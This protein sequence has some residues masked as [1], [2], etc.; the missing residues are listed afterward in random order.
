MY[1]DLTYILIPHFFFLLRLLSLIRIHIIYSEK[2]VTC[3]F[4]TNFF[5]EK[6]KRKTRK[7]KFQ[8]QHTNSIS[9]SH[10]SHQMRYTFNNTIIIIL[11]YFKT[12]HCCVHVR[13]GVEFFWWKT[14][15]NERNDEMEKSRKHGS[16]REKTQ[17]YFLVQRQMGIVGFIR[18][19]ISQ[20]CGLNQFK[21]V[22]TIP[23][24]QLGNHFPSAFKVFAKNLQK[25]KTRLQL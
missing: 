6:K 1:I 11:Y 21:F 14:D 19:R 8:T 10:S 15:P 2:W 22:S 24:N 20:Q 5:P 23:G 18:R 13:H 4:V 25:R 9:F 7:I 3:D 17:Q 12:L 16:K